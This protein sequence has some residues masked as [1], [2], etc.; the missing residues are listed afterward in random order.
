MSILQS[1]RA[2][3][4]LVLGAG[5]PSVDAGVR[6]R[7]ATRCPFWGPGRDCLT[8]PASIPLERG[9][10]FLKVNSSGVYL[11]NSRWASGDIIFDISFGGSPPCSSL[12]VD[13][14]ALASGMFFWLLAKY[15]TPS[16]LFED[17]HIST[18]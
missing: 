2:I 17:G 9:L 7:A 4:C 10:L 6:I 1:A 8:S 3:R 16:L 14:Q 5:F 11:S 15:V 13:G 18:T 12:V